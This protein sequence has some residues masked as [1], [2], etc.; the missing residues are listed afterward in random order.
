[1][2]PLLVF[3]QKYGHTL[4]IRGLLKFSNWAKSII[5]PYICIYKYATMITLKQG[6][7][8]SATIKTKKIYSN[9]E[10]EFS[11]TVINSGA[12]ETLP[13]T[14]LFTDN[15]ACA[16]FKVYLKGGV[17]P[18]GESE[19]TLIYDGIY[20]RDTCTDKA[21]SLNGSNGVLKINCAGGG[22]N[23]LEKPVIQNTSVSLNN[24]T[25]FNFTD[26]SFTSLYYSPIASPLTEISFWGDVF[27][28]T[29][30][31]DSYVA[32]TFIPFAD[33]NDVLHIAPNVDSATNY[34]IFYSVKDAEGNVSD[35]ALITINNNVLGTIV[36]VNK[37]INIKEEAGVYSNTF[38]LNYSGATG[39][40]VTLGDFVHDLS[41]GDNYFSIS[42]NETKTL[43]GSGTLEFEITG[44]VEEDGNA[45]FSFVLFGTVNMTINVVVE[46]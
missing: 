5:R 11:V 12:S 41:I 32:N 42:V 38:L 36:W 24:R 30:D 2:I 40:S 46:I 31:G 9:F 3:L 21:I 45:S 1:M 13:N 6:E 27:T 43:V 25:D 35:S 20:K 33:I 4:T 8:F 16:T 22:E 37:F 34:G 23:P 15:Y 39:Q 10:S 14:L 17:V 18:N 29:Y 28:I 44:S 26:F 19:V 7:D